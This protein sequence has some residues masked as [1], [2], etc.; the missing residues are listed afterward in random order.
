[1]FLRKSLQIHSMQL[2]CLF[3]PLVI[4]SNSLTQ[5]LS[6]QNKKESMKKG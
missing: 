3:S 2:R 5:L 4:H 6:L 1:M